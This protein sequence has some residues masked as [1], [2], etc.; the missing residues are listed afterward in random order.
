MENI[1]RKEHWEKVYREKQI[2]ELSWYEEKPK[3]SLYF[4]KKFHL[5][6]TAKI[7]DIGGGDSFFVDNLLE[8]GYSDVSVLD[9]SI[10]S[11]DK[12]KKRLGS[13]SKNVKWIL[14]DII[15]FDPVDKY[16]LWH[17]RAAFHFLTSEH[18]IKS[19]IKIIKNHIKPEGYLILGTF[20]EKGPEKC[21]G[22]KIKQYSEISMSERLKNF[23]KKI[24]CIRVNHRTPFDTIQKFVFCGFQRK[25]RLND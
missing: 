9:I 19:Y 14:S 6:K 11:L 23:F 22:L 13:K 5:P 25:L 4:L 15:D 16:D 17:D 1:N 24:K 10:S 12:A 18:D 2:S 3:T 8:H 20:S 7:I 21:S